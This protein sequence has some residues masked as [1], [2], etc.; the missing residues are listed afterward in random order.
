MSPPWFVSSETESGHYLKKIHSLYRIADCD[1]CF[2]AGISKPQSRLN[3]RTSLS[4]YSVPLKSSCGGGWSRVRDLDT[5]F[6]QAKRKE[7]PGALYPSTA[8]KLIGGRQHGCFNEGATD[9]AQTELCQELAPQQ[10]SIIWMLTSATATAPPDVT[11]L[12]PT[13]RYCSL[14]SLPC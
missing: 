1:I 14:R 3:I 2:L 8:Y 11:F 6:G 12:F 13:L 7:L 9:S 4:Y 10:Y 5:W